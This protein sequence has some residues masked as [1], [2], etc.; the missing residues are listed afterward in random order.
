MLAVD[1]D[2]C[3]ES[4]PCANN[5]SCSDE[6]SGFSCTCLDGFTGET[7][8]VGEMLLYEYKKRVL[9]VLYDCDIVS[10]STVGSPRLYYCVEYRFT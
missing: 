8:D 5:G 10:V 7:C 3:A 9:F 4:N 2:P 6:G 1:V